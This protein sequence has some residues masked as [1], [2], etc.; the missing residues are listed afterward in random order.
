MHHGTPL[1]VYEEKDKGHS[2]GHTI[3]IRAAG[4]TTVGCGFLLL[5]L[6]HSNLRTGKSQKGQGLS[7]CDSFTRVI[8]SSCASHYFFCL[9]K[10]SLG[11]SLFDSCTGKVIIPRKIKFLTRTKVKTCNKVQSF[12]DTCRILT[13]S[14]GDDPKTFRAEDAPSS[15]SVIN[16]LKGKGVEHI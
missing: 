10:D 14:K 15:S 6:F 7:Q 16:C 5:L 3:L 8:I 1:S 9:F 2:T 11:I 13:R 4:K 12:K